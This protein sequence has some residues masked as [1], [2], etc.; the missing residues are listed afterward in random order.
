MLR[1]PSSDGLPQTR[2]QQGPAPERIGV[3]MIAIPEGEEVTVEAALS[4]LG[5][6]ISVDAHIT[7]TLR[8]QC[9]RCLTELE[10]PLDLRISQIYAA[11]PDFISGD[12]ADEGEQGSGD[13]TPLI[14]RDVID[15]SQDVINE[16]GLTLPFSPVCEQPCTIETPEG[17]TTGVSGEEIDERWAGLEKFL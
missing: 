15:I 6:A 9:A 5:G 7:G 16:A 1:G 17:V 11:D 12:P 13:E 10:R 2:T 4:P 14:D 3:E 8:G